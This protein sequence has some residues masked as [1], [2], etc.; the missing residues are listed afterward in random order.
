MPR[1]FRA[2]SRA[3]G[4]LRG[5]PSEAIREDRR[6]MLRATVAAGAG[7]LLSGCAGMSLGRSHGRRVIV[8]GAGFA[9]LACAYELR[10]VGYDV[11]VIDARKRVGG[12]VLTLRDFVPGK[13]VEGGAELIGSNHPHWQAYADRFGLSMLDMSDEEVPIEIGGRLVAGEEGEALWAGIE[14][15]CA[16]LNAWAAK[17]DAERPWVGTEAAAFDARPVAW[18]IRG[19]TG[20]SAEVRSALAANLGG[21]NGVDVEHLSLLAMLS[22]VKGGGLSRFWSETEVYRCAGGN[23]QL[24]ERFA[25]DLGASRVRLGTPATAID[26]SGPVCRVT[27]ADG[28]VEEGDDV[29]LAV[30][31]TTWP[32]L[33]VKPWF[34][35]PAGVQLGSNVKYC[36]RVKGPFWKASGRSAY[37][38]SDGEINWTWESTD[39]QGEGGGAGLT[40]FCGGAGSEAVRARSPESRDRRMAETIERWFPGYGENLA[41]VRFMDWPSDPWTLGAYSAYAPG[42]ITS[43]GPML[44]AGLGRLH[45]AGE[46]CSF[47]FMGYMEGALHSGAKTAWTIAKRDGVRLPVRQPLPVEEAPVGA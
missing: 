10:S 45:F 41:G 42:Q 19:L 29:V 28:R 8:V 20:H 43:A 31:P 40:A 4:P 36:T 5:V 47:A 38:L 35:S 26:A 24:A 33:R 1:F 25:R 22:Q 9:G 3:F 46:H 15:C 14:A 44:E 2:L 21:D 13:V 39:G 11:V 37:T 17:V 7:L 12:R 23:Q 16:R 27:L 32:K 34:T 18:W 6:R 30:P